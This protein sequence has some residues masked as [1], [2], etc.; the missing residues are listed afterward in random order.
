MI[1]G[2]VCK[3]ALLAPRQ[4]SSFD[5]S[6]VMK[7]ATNSK[8]DREGNCTEFKGKGGKLIMN[9]GIFFQPNVA[10]NSSL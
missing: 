2:D 10:A 1:R 8:V 9:R 4:N 3:D 5:S 7:I 6:F